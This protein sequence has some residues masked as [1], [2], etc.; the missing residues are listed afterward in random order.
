M[1]EQKKTKTGYKETH[2][3]TQSVS[4]VKK[5]HVHVNG[6]LTAEPGLGPVGAC[7]VN[8]YITVVLYQVSALTRLVGRQE[9]H[10][11]CEN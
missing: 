2:T 5:S 9:G 8:F 11:A 6:W 3:H 7:S 10:P 4:E 1:V